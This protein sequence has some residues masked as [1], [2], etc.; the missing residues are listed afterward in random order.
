MHPAIKIL[1]KIPKGKVTTY[2]AIAKVCGTSPRAVGSLMRCNQNPKEYPCYKVVKNTGEIGG[3][4]GSEKK[5]IKKKI[6][7]LKKDGIEIRNGKVDLKK[8]MYK[9]R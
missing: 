8:I 6:L 3:Y 9:F 7:L 5:K 2:G 1:K 4:D